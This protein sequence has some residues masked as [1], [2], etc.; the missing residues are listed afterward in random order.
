MG[1]DIA[2]KRRLD[3]VLVERGLVET[4]ERA[5]WLIRR[6]NVQVEGKVVTKPSFRVFPEA[7][8]HL[9]GTLPYVSRGGLKLESALKSFGVNPEGWV[10]LDV[11]TSTGGF[12]DCLLQWGARRVYAVDV[13]RGQLAPQLRQDP[14]VVL[15]EDTDIRHLL[16]LPE[17]VDLAVIDVSFISLRQ[18][19]PSVLRF[20]KP[21]E[22]QI[23]ALM[24]PQFETGSPHLVK[25]GV[26]RDP[27]LR[28]K[29][30]AELLAWFRE[31]GLEVLGFLPSPIPGGEGN[32]EYLVHLK[33]LQRDVS[34]DQPAF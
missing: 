21:Q 5:Q 15:Y 33:P 31:Q 19:I 34:K 20:L 18:V 11:G 26:I 14:R 23:I 24:K 9:L 32:V 10:A 8:L 29:I 7:D 30:V 13:G 1:N 27:N 6:G 28:Q 12:T 25:K 17:P 22:G 16:T 4:R 3:I 2:V